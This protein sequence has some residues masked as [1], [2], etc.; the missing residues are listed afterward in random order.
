MDKTIVIWLVL[1]NVVALLVLH[2]RLTA[3]GWDVPLQDTVDSLLEAVGVGHGAYKQCGLL[4]TTTFIL[5]SSR[6]VWPD[7]VRPGAGEAAGGRV[8][9]LGCAAACGA[10]PTPAAQRM[11]APPPMADMADTPCDCTCCCSVHVKGGKITAVRDAPPKSTSKRV[12]DYGNAVIMPGVIDVHVHLNE[13]GREDWEGAR[14]SACKPRHHSTASGHIAAAV[15][16]QTQ[17]QQ[18][19]WHQQ[20]GKQYRWYCLQ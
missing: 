9:V 3:I 12:I 18:Q 11:P 2:Q 20:Q 4:N 1:A 6:V 5:T 10:P 14:V 19:Q 15:L 17:Q 8:P 13:P 7:G 16:P